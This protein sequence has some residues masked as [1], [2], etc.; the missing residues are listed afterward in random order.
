MNSSRLGPTHPAEA[1]F[2]VAVPREKPAV[3][4]TTRTTIRI[5]SSAGVERGRQ[6]TLMR[7]PN[8]K[9]RRLSLR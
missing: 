6:L 3:F 8:A 5:R 1:G 7:F 2:A 9:D 4:V